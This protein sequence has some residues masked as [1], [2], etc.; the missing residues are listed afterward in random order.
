MYDLINLTIYA[1]RINFEAQIKVHSK[2]R[3]VGI[4]LEADCVCIDDTKRSS[5][6]KMSNSKYDKN[7]I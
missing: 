5:M 7:I 2:V 3:L 1:F 6:A 4:Q